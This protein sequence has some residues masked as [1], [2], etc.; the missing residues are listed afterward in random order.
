MDI[1]YISAV[2]YNFININKL[3][4]LDGG[5]KVKNKIIDK[6]DVEFI[7]C[8]RPYKWDSISTKRGLVL[9]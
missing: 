9:D 4:N 1:V 7:R 8:Y 3:D 6:K 2:V 5:L